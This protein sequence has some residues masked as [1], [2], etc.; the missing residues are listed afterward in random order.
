[1]IKLSYSGHELESGKQF[2]FDQLKKNEDFVVLNSRWQ[3][4][5]STHRCFNI[6]PSEKRKAGDGIHSSAQA[7]FRRSRRKAIL[8][9]SSNCSCAPDARA[10]RRKLWH[11][12]VWRE[13]ISSHQKCSVTSIAGQSW[14]TQQEQNAE[15]AI[16]P[17]SNETISG[18]AQNLL[19]FRLWSFG[20]RGLRF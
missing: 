13:G 2:Q 5:L 4:V 8:H 11:G 9:S 19:L 18:R 10:G 1:M 17:S 6:C 14:A 20:L 12:R 7:L 3:Q 16:Q 15:A